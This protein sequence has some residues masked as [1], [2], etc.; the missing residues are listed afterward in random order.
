[1]AGAT[2]GQRLL[3]LG[4][5]TIA[6]M[7]PPVLLGISGQF[8]LASS[9]VYGGIV[10]IT[11][12]FYGLRLAVL[13][14]FASGVAAAAAYLLH[15]YAIAGAIFFGLLT[16]VCAI[17]ARRGLHS[18]ALMVPIF[19]AFI[20]AAPPS[21]DGSTGLASALVIGAVMALG[22]L[23]ATASARILMG[24]KLPHP[25]AHPVRPSTSVLYAVLMAVILGVA[26]WGVLTY[27]NFHQ[28]AWLLLT[29][30]IVLQPSP[31]DTFTMS[32][33][34]LGGTLIGGVIALVFILAGVEAT[35]A[36]IVGGIFI[37][38]ALTL[39]YVFKR[40]YWEYVTVLTP[41]AILLN[42]PG[43]DP[44]S[45]AEDRVVFTVIG[46]LVGI[47]VAM[48]IKWLVLWRAPAAESS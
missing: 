40:P 23:W 19:V 39:R 28:G 2:R 12:V 44:I 43:R 10:A 4:L 11:A 46:T 38:A 13:L 30:I 26:A 33:Q 47:A 48:G 18:P 45:V 41:A 36:L 6:L 14:S 22:G 35:L 8:G 34:R 15:P 9:F 37:F 29:L 1:M 21:V 25:D 5:L 7:A 16:G 31:H 3:I 32:L 17:T 27:A 24:T 20:L 42:T